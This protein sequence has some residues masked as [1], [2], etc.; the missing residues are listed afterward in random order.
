MR[1]QSENHP[2][3]SLI[4]EKIE[5]AHSLYANW[6]DS[7]KQDPNIHRLLQELQRKI[8]NTNKTMLKISVVAECKH[9]EEEEGGSCCGA[10]IENRY[11][12]VDLLI[13]LLLGISLPTLRQCE[14][15][16]HFLGENGCSLTARHVLCVNYIC[17]TIQ[18]KFSQEQLI[19][20][21]S[22][23]GEQLDTGFMLHEAIK[24]RLRGSS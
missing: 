16:C 9:C 21:Q 6:G 11:G 8:E 18:R 17:S 20:L 23:A 19:A 13:N 15:S 22:C 2:D 10:G 7:L 5:Q 12:V 3:S 24:K 1:K 4:E 14:N